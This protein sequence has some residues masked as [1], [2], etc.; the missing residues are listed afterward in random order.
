L[1]AD[2]DLVS[3]Q[4]IEGVQRFKRIEGAKEALRAI[5]DK[6]LPSGRQTADFRALIAENRVP[7]MIVWGER[8]TVLDPAAASGMPSS[9]EVVL[10][11][12]AGH[13]P[14]MEASSVVNERLRGHFDIADNQGER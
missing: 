9:V 11:E 12:S 3:A 13:M 14:H 10:V 7:L 1:L 6:N 2:P 8:D 5:A 4:M